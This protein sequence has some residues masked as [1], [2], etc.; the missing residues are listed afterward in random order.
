MDHDF[1]DNLLEDSLMP[2]IGNKIV[3]FRGGVRISGALFLV[4]MLHTCVHLQPQAARGRGWTGSKNKGGGGSD[5]EDEEDEEQCS[6]CAWCRDNACR[7]ADQEVHIVAVDMGMGV[8]D[9]ELDALVSDTGASRGRGSISVGQD[10]DLGASVNADGESGESLE[11]RLAANREPG[12]LCELQC[13]VPPGEARSA[14]LEAVDSGDQGD[15]ATML[16]HLL[17]LKSKSKDST[18]GGV[19]LKVRVDARGGRL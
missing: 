8:L 1:D 16:S 10:T 11:A 6:E 18:S 5:S 2:I 14:L 4:S 9:L 19:I 15:T 12:M 7:E 13:V 17:Y 3:L